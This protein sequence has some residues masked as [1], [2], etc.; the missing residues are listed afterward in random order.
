VHGTEVV[1]AVIDN[2]ELIGLI[3]L[4]YSL[5]QEL[6]LVQGKTIDLQKIWIGNPILVGIEIMEVAQ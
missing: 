3:G 5:D 2:V 1:N 4:P 6:E